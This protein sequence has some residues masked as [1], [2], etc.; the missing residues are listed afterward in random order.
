MSWLLLNV[1]LFGQTWTT[2]TT[3]T[4]NIIEAA[5]FFDANTG[6]VVGEGGICLVT[7]NGGST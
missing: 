5:F 3:P 2:Q 1:S 6:W 7:T 4:T